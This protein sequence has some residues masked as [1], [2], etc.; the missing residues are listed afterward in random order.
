MAARETLAIMIVL[1][2]SVLLASQKSVLKNSLPS[3][4]STTIGEQKANMING[5]M[6]HKACKVPAS[7]GKED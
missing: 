4:D 7:I 6:E 2:I 5:T 3:Q 1:L